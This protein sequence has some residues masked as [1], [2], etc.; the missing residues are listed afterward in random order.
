LQ[1]THGTFRTLVGETNKLNATALD[2]A[3]NAAKEVVNT[4][5]VF[6]EKATLKAETSFSTQISDVRS[7]LDLVAS[8]LGEK[9][10]SNAMAAQALSGRITVIESR[11]VG[12]TESKGVANTQ[13]THILSLCSIFI[14]AIAVILV[15][16]Q[17]LVRSPEPPATT[18]QQAPSYGTQNVNPPTK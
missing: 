15:V 12:A 16:I 2:A 18:F 3:F 5:Q 17:M 8:N 11:G 1:E 9:I 4:A 10:D 6:N 13:T 7:R 14:A